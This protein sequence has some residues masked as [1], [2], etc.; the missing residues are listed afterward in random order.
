MPEEQLLLLFWRCRTP[1]I[2][3]L[4]NSATH[5]LRR[6]I[7][8]TH[9]KSIGGP[10]TTKHNA[11]LA[12]ALTS[13]QIQR[14]LLLYVYTAGISTGDTEQ[15]HNKRLCPGAT[16]L[17]AV[18]V[19]TSR[20]PAKP[21]RA[22]MLFA[23]IGVE[24]FM[25]GSLSCSPQLNPRPRTFFNAFHPQYLPQ[26]LR[27]HTYKK[28]RTRLA[29]RNQRPHYNDESSMHHTTS[30]LSPSAKPDPENAQTMHHEIQ[31]CAA[32]QDPDSQVPTTH[33]TMKRV[34]HHTPTL[35]G[36][37]TPQTPIQRIHGQ[38]PGEIQ[39]L[40]PSAK[41]NPENAQTTHHK[42]QECTATQ[43]PDSRV[44][45]THTTTK[46]VQCHTPALA[47]VWQY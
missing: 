19:M 21:Q 17:S 40:S 12:D 7:E 13:A 28:P 20:L 42:T 26:N 23:L 16:S 39:V 2:K 30:V 38:G 10:T 41:P 9:A 24:T 46:Q 18:G 14:R 45:T 8:R 15:S 4:P 5:P 37:L 29:E 47:G 3:N 44:P 35:A 1:Q 33:M 32:T 34:W 43:D 36:F 6:A 31:E 11:R 27:Y 22:E 25:G